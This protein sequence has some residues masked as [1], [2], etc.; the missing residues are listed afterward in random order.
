MTTGSLSVT[1]SSITS[2]AADLPLFH[3]VSMPFEN[4]LRNN[5][6]I[7]YIERYL[8]DQGSGLDLPAAIILE[9]VQGEGGIN[10]ASDEWLRN[11]EKIC[12]RF[13]ILLI[14]DDIQAGCGR[15]GTFF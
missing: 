5:G 4:Y 6:S 2:R 7:E 14:V 1:R 12:R 11:I 3:S 10:A 13:D 9:T 8:E 15:T